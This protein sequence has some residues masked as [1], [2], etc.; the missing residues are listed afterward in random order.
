[1]LL[2]IPGSLA[3]IVRAYKAAVAR[4]ISE[5]RGT[6]GVAVWQRGYHERIIRSEQHLD[7]ARAYIM[8]NPRR[9]AE[10]QFNPANAA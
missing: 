8:D 1:M 9:W 2:V 10:D 7:A 6:P 4:R 3:A 5:L